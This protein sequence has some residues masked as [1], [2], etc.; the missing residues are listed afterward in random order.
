MGRRG[1]RALLVAV[2]LVVASP[3]LRPGTPDGFPL[4]TYPMFA[5]R[6]GTEVAVATAVRVDDAGHRHRLDPELIGGTGEVMLAATTVRLAV[7][8]GTTAT[9]RLC[10]EIADRLQR[11]PDTVA[12]ELRTE[13]HDADAWFR[14]RRRPLRVEVH[15]R[16]EVLG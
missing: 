6:P 4:S 2:G 7:S 13:V 5:Q 9:R 1:R 14:G 10:D 12:V 8:D 15:H 16:C 3:A 11:G